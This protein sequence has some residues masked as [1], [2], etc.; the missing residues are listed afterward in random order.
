M[1]TVP[2]NS[3]ANSIDIYFLR[4]AR[5]VCSVPETYLKN[6]TFRFINAVQNTTPLDPDANEVNLVHILNPVSLRIIFILSVNIT[7]FS[8]MVTFS[9]LPYSLLCHGNYMSCKLRYSWYN[10]HSNMIICKGTVVPVLKQLSTAPW[11]QMGNGS[12]APPFWISA[13]DGGE[14]SASCPTRFNALE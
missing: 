2:S 7:Q 10:R 1:C 14:W 8:K 5:P 11:R 6:I 9:Y 12:I 4:I 3:Q 13:L